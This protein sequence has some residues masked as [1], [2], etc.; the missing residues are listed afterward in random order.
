VWRRRLKPPDLSRGQLG[1]V[2]AQHAVAVSEEIGLQ[3]GGD[4][5]RRPEARRQAAGDEGDTVA[6]APHARA[7]M[8]VRFGRDPEIGHHRS[9]YALW[10]SVQ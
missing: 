2:L 1:I 10:L 7:T 5:D 3:L 6:S 4:A 8:I 9:A